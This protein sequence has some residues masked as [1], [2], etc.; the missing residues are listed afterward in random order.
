MDGGMDI[1]LEQTRRQETYCTNPAG[2]SPLG[3]DGR[4]RGPEVGIAVRD[5]KGAQIGPRNG[6]MSLGDVA[7]APPPPL[8]GRPSISWA[9]IAATSIDAAA[10]A[11]DAIRVH[12]GDS[13]GDQNRDPIGGRGFDVP[14][15]GAYSA[16]EYGRACAAPWKSQCRDAWS[17][18][19]PA[20][21]AQAPMRTIKV[22]GAFGAYVDN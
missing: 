18:P 9:R 6:L 7:H 13:T 14:C 12:R 17:T 5:A 2:W 15:R 19:S 22:V 1:N 10:Q 11:R 4:D 16:G 20:F 3:N 8:R 21:F